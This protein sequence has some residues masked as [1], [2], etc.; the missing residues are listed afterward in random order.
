MTRDQK[1]NFLVVPITIAIVG[2]VT[3]ILALCKQD[4]KYYLIGG[5]LGLMC[6]GLMVKQNARMLRMTRLDPTHTTYN[7]K[8]STILWYLL[9]FALVLVVFVVLGFLAKDKPRKDFVI[10]MII[11]LAGYLTLKVIFLIMLLCIREKVVKEW[12]CC[13]QCQAQ[14]GRH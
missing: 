7:P 11:A 9:R 14:L 8:K 2:I 12:P 10:S 6:H 4:W 5:M 13:I 3:L 1:I